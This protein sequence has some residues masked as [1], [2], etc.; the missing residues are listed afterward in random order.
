MASL[1]DCGGTLLARR[2]DERVARQPEQV[3]RALGELDE[4]PGFFQLGALGRS[5]AHPEPGD[6]F[7]VRLPASGDAGHA[8]VAGWP[9]LWNGGRC[10]M[11]ARAVPGLGDYVCPI[12]WSG[13]GPRARRRA[14]GRGAGLQPPVG[15]P[16]AARRPAA[17]A[18]SPEEGQVRRC[19]WPGT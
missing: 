13:R 4:D 8:G 2:W 3:R 16:R 12:E 19:A 1:G 11:G 15:V 9:G 18:A 17:I 6:T 5:R 14:R 7:R 10:A